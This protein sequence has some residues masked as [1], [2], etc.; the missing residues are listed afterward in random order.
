[1][2]RI[3]PPVPWSQNV[4]IVGENNPF[5]AFKTPAAC[6]LY[7]AQEHP[8]HLD[9]L[10]QGIVDAGATTTSLCWDAIE[11]AE[12]GHTTL[13]EQVFALADN[14]RETMDMGDTDFLPPSM[15]SASEIVLKATAA[16]TLVK[17]KERCEGIRPK[18]RDHP[19]AI[20]M[21]KQE[22]QKLQKMLPSSP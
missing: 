13:A 7:V 12:I 4:Q 1:M 17:I 2:Y 16:V 19:N 14:P 22:W 15:T 11:L 6:I 18:W 8:K 3:R 10:L 5:E 9:A 20:Q 21:Q